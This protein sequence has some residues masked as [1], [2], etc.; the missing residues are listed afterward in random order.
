VASS[1]SSPLAQSITS[2]IQSEVCFSLG[3][4]ARS[5]SQPS[6]KFAPSLGSIQFHTELHSSNPNFDRWTRSMRTMSLILIAISILYRRLYLKEHSS[7][8]LAGRTYP[9][10]CYKWNLKNPC[11]LCMITMRAAAICLALAVPVFSVVTRQNVANSLTIST[12]GSFASSPLLYG[13]MYEVWM[14]YHK[15]V[16]SDH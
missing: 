14:V 13:Y 15:D 8:L 3:H 6:V 10:E 16:L 5:I 1:A 9:E 11:E 7:R 2:G 4:N 12:N